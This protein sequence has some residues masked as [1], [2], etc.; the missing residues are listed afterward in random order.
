MTPDIHALDLKVSALS[1][2]LD[3]TKIDENK[4]LD[5]LLDLAKQIAVIHEKQLNSADSVKRVEQAI[6]DVSLTSQALV[7]DANNKCKKIEEDRIKADERLHDRVDETKVQVDAIALRVTD[8]CKV[9]TTKLST[10]THTLNE[11]FEA[12]QLEYQNKANFVKG[13]FVALSAVAALTQ[14]LVYKYV[15]SIER[16]TIEDKQL[17]HKIDNKLI[18]TDRQAE[19]M[20]MRLRQL[21]K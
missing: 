21:T 16:S 11:Q 10:E 6:K 12:F 2:S 1:A 3:V 7:A 9:S 19:L 13:V 8:E 18:E 17:L 14:T 4:R 15:D 20:H 5:L